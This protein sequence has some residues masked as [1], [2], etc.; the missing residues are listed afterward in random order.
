MDSKVDRVDSVFDARE[1]VAQKL[2]MPMEELAA[3]WEEQEQAEAWARAIQLVRAKQ[4]AKARAGFQQALWVLNRDLYGLVGQRIMGVWVEYYAKNLLDLD[5]RSFRILMAPDTALGQA[6]SLADP[7]LRASAIVST[8]PTSLQASQTDPLAASVPLPSDMELFDDLGEAPE[9]SQGIAQARLNNFV[10]A[11]HIFTRAGTQ[12]ANQ[13]GR[14]MKKDISFGKQWALFYAAVAPGTKK[15]WNDKMFEEEYRRQEQQLVQSKLSASLQQQTMAHSPELN[16]T[17]VTAADVSVK[18]DEPDLQ[19]TMRSSPTAASPPPSLAPQSAAGPQPAATVLTPRD[20][21]PEGWVRWETTTGVPYFHN[22]VTRVSQWDAPTEPQSAKPTIVF[23]DESPQKNKRG[24]EKLY[25]QVRPDGVE[26]GRGTAVDPCTSLAAA[27]R[28]AEPGSEICLLSCNLPPLVIVNPPAN[29]TIRA[30]EEQLVIVSTQKVDQ[31]LLFVAQANNLTLADIVFRGKHDTIGV[32][33]VDCEGLQIR[34][35]QFHDVQTPL[36]TETGQVLD[37]SNLQY[38]S[39]GLLKFLRMRVAYWLAAV[40]YLINVFWIIV[41]LVWLGGLLADMNTKEM[42][43]QWI[44]GLF[45]AFGL[46]FIIL[47]PIKVVLFHMLFRCA[48]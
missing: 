32:E 40:A 8:S 33:T 45:V 21:P 2:N 28:M 23:E 48:A 35:C 38:R 37:K 36:A 18:D 27:L 30:A 12:I 6:A 9:W 10:K 47:Q 20:L 43:G 25:V 3:S 7:R 41:S 46:D 17:S 4:F 44:G 14:Q 13:G 1:L 39:S 34:D 29:I 26:G 5:V 31:T 11:A 24:Q 42:F 16:V 19:I 15:K 22:T